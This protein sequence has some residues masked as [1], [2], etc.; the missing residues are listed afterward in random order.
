VVPH[1]P[2]RSRSVNISRPALRVVMGSV[3]AIPLAAVVL[4]YTTVSKSVDLARLQRLDRQNRFLAEQLQRTQQ[5]VTELTDTMTVIVKRNQQVR[6]L[7]GLEPTDPEV[8]LAGIGGPRPRS[9]TG[10]A[11]AE[12]PLGQ[13]AL[14]A[15]A[16][17]STLIRRA[18]L[19]AKSYDEAL[20]SLKS[21]TDQMQRTPSIW[22]VDG[23][24]T[25]AYMAQRIHP[26]HGDLRA[27]EGIDVSAPMGSPIRVAAGGLVI[28]AGTESGYGLLVTVDHGY[29]MV[30]RYA[31]CSKILV[32]VGQRVKRGDV[33]ANVGNTGIATG[34]HLHYE[35]LR[36]GK[37]MDPK[38]FIFP[39]TI[40]D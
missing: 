9:E 32:R 40:V 11:L 1:G 5:M 3:L 14:S 2:G 29:G 23:W 30:T 17:V 38:T 37:H 4:A 20:D 36:G 18:N 27:H 13:S 35:V 22:P 10:A 28:D 7:A 21:R 25:S 19:L 26:I 15:R 31:H 16:E 12:E 39:K 8:Q 33:I 34:P 24:L 6:V